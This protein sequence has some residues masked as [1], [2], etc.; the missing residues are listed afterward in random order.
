MFLFDG[1]WSNTFTP[2]EILRDMAP[3]FNSPCFVQRLRRRFRRA[4][5]TLIE[6]HRWKKPTVSKPNV[7]TYVRK[8]GVII[9]PPQTV[10]CTIFVG[11]SG[12]PSKLHQITIVLA[13]TFWTPA[14]W[15]PLTPWKHRPEPELLDDLGQRIRPD[16]N[17]KLDSNTIFT[18]WCIKNKHL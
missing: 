2:R 15:V 14:K 8:Q 18:F 10:S 11:K 1:C 16:S 17:Q 4:S 9:L 13:S 5:K 12:N 3:S 6:I 7:K